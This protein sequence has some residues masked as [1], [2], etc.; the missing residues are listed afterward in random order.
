MFLGYR[1]LPRHQGS[2]LSGRGSMPIS[3]NSSFTC[4]RSTA[5]LYGSGRPVVWIRAKYDTSMISGVTLSGISMS[6]RSAVIRFPPGQGTAIADAVFTKLQVYSSPFW[7]KDHVR[8]TGAAYCMVITV[9]NSLVETT[10][11]S[12]CFGS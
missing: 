1:Y 2:R 12:P 6:I 5:I 10:S 11:L 7:K 8:F 9:P 4:S 3:A